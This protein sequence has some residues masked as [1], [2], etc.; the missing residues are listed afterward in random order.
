[1]AAWGVGRAGRAVGRRRCQGASL[2]FGGAAGGRA[3]ASVS[4]VPRRGASGHGTRGER[5]R[6]KNPGFPLLCYACGGE[7]KRNSAVQNG[8]VWF[9]FFFFFFLKRMKRRRFIKCGAINAPTF[10]SVPQLFLF[11]SIAS[12]P[13]SVS[14]A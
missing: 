7:K 13:I 1:M 12:L 10:T 3:V 2:G 14:S 4:G 9:F 8:T 5:G 11:L 6:D